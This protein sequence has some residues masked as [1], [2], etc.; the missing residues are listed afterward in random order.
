LPAGGIIP[1][2]IPFLK[3]SVLYEVKF[4]WIPNDGLANDD[5]VDVKSDEFVV[6]LE[7]SIPVLLPE[8]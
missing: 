1:V 3:I 4:R 7:V 5:S 8:M 2:F 6:P